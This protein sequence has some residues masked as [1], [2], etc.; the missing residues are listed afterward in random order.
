MTARTDSASSGS[1]YSRDEASKSV[2][3]V[4]G[5]ELIMTACQPTA[6]SVSAACT[7]Q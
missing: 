2:D 4:S 6:R 7:A 1:K 5:F 3:T